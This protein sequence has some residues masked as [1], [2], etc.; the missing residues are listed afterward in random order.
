M[1]VGFILSTCPFVQ[2]WRGFVGGTLSLSNNDDGGFT[3][4]GQ[5][6]YNYQI[7][8]FV[9]G[10]EADIQWADT[11]QNINAVFVPAPGFVA[12]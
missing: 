3:G 10:A 9:I 8:S 12:G 5:I 4:G 1:S 2:G 6:G 7:G 11:D